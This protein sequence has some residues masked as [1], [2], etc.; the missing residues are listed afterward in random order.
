MSQFIFISIKD[1]FSPKRQKLR[2]AIFVEK[3]QIF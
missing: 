1:D 2:L 3:C